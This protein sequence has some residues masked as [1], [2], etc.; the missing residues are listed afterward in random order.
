[1]Q[2]MANICLTCESCQGRRFKEE[3]LEVK[4]Q[5]KD[6]CDILDMTVDDSLI[7]FADQ[8]PIVN[9]LAPLQEIGMGYVRLGQ[10]SNSLSG[11]EAQRIKLA[12][13]L[14]K[15]QQQQHTLFIFDEPTTGLHVHDIHKL[16]KAI[17][18]LIEQGNSVLVIEHNTEM[19]KC[20]DWVIDLGPEGG[21]RGGE[22][23]FEGTPEA[24]V[25]LENNHTAQYL[26]EKLG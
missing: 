2:F 21:E 7:F 12:A 17:N 10:S 9:K 13:Y 24:M 3:T 22:V 26:K 4:Y 20:A 6:I 15:G 11:G 25:Q 18:A 16:L 8:S 14:S 23:V 19:I 5:G 1:M